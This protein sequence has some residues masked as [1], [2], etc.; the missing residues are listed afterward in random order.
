MPALPDLAVWPRRFGFKAALPAALLVL[1]AVLPGAQAG[2]ETGYTVGAGDVLEISVTGLPDLKQRTTVNPD[3]SIMVPLVGSS[4]A[5]GLSLAEVH[6]RVQDALSGKVFRQRLPDGKDNFIPI[7]RDHVLVNVVEMR[8]FY[9]G[10]DVSKPGEYAFR[11][12]MT[13]RKA[14]ALA[15]G[16]DSLRQGGKR[17]ATEASDWLSEYDGLR[18]DSAEHKVRL[19]RLRS[20]LDEV[21]QI[22]TKALVN[23]PV[24][25]P[26]LS[27]IT[28][29]EIGQLQTNLDDLNS[30]R[31]YYKTVKTKTTTQ[32]DSLLKQKQQEEIG[33]E[34]QAADL[35]RVKDQFQRGLTPITQFT[36]EQRSYLLASQR[37][38]QI[39][40]QAAEVERIR[41]DLG[42]QH[43]KLEALRRTEL[44][45]KIEESELK[46]S[47]NAFRMKALE[48]KL[49]STGSLKSLSLYDIKK[50]AEI[51]L[52]RIE[53]SETREFSASEDSRVLPGD[54]IEVSLQIISTSGSLDH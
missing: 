27:R 3:G 30:Q 35:A 48:E 24:Q 40:A 51:R 18:T 47:K 23:M 6:A 28:N 10:G 21:A 19:V 34:Q 13:V 32:I 12:G 17:S 38:L 8:P 2:P 52:V 26:L 42:N 1:L 14:V 20:E 49:L 31:A 33:L 29:L 5:A 45:K 44:M 25:A 15:G 37:V 53:G 7:G 36:S 50:K 41:E 4:P 43:Q 22:D 16:Y 11:T 9:V 39:T 54:L 46:L